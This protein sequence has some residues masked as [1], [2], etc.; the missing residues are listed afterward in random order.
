M[1]TEK[2]KQRIV[3]VYLSLVSDKTH[4][5]IG[6]NEI[7]ETAGLTLAQLRQAYGSKTEMIMDF[8]RRID[9][10]VLGEI[11]EG[12]ADEPAR[13]RLFDIIMRRLDALSPH[14]AAVAGLMRSARRDPVLGAALNAIA[15]GS[16][17]WMLT[18]AGLDP[19]G[20]MG[21]ARAQALALGYAQVLQV[22]LEEED[23]GLP[24]TMARL[25]RVLKRLEEIGGMTERLERG[26]ARI[27]RMGRRGR[28]RRGRPTPPAA[29][30][31]GGE[32]AAGT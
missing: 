18:A 24:K 21:I 31:N 19:G 4:G 13:E 1:A 28:R 29:E 6:L 2:Q 20:L 7:A 25:D 27:M 30:T 9:A 8:A 5:A 12:M 32:A 17:R 14:K 22:W 3:D 15:I 16:Q 11:D 10:E 26:C 23:P